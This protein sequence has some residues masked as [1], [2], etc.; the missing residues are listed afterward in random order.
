MKLLLIRMNHSTKKF[1]YLF[2]NQELFLSYFT[3]KI[4]V[5]SMGIL[6]LL[7]LSSMQR[8]NQALVVFTYPLTI[9]PN[10]ACGP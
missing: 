5:V 7:L 10:M 3:S 2:Q 9:P 4:K 1:P 8:A 6:Y